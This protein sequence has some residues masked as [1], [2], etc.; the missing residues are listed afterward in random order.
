MISQRPTDIISNTHAHTHTHT[1]TDT[2]THTH[3]HRDYLYLGYRYD[4][5]DCC[6]N[7]SW[8]SVCDCVTSGHHRLHKRH[9]NNDDVRGRACV[10]PSRVILITRDMLAVSEHRR[11]SLRARY[12]LHPPVNNGHDNLSIITPTAGYHHNTDT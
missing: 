4:N 8:L 11:S 12:R 10:L 6:D 5:R 2:H 7:K 3:T 1:Q 9:D